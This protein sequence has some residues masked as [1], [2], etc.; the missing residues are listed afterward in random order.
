MKTAP[1]RHPLHPALAHFPVAFW[2]GASACDLIAL[3]T[4]GVAWWTVSHYAI[5]AGVIM[6]ALALAAGLLELWLRS[7][8]GAAVRW[9]TVHASLMSLALVCF[10]VSLSQRTTTPPTAAA[11]ALSFLGSAVVL[12]GGF[13]GGTLVYRFGVGVSQGR[14]S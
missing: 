9:V 10:M 13:C 11:L 14:E 5:A 2:L 7:L 3:R 12:A 4:G 8:P 1:L 6:G